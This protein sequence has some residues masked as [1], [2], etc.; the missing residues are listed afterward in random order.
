MQTAKKI[1]TRNTEKKWDK[2]N[3]PTRIDMSVSVNR[4]VHKTVYILYSIY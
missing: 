2:Q 4:E 3:R 1:Q